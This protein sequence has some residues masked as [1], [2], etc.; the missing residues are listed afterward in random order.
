MDLLLQVLWKMCDHV[1]VDQTTLLTVSL[2]FPLVMISMRMP[3]KT[4]LQTRN[5]Q[6]LIL[7]KKWNGCVCITCAVRRL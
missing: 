7:L 2:T 4:L 6:V 5:H 1:I 3:G